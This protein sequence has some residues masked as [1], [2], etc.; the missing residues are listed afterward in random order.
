MKKCVDVIPSFFGVV[1]MIEHKRGLRSSYQNPFSFFVGTLSREGFV[2]QIKNFFFFGK[3]PVPLSWE[4][5][6]LCFFSNGEKTT[7]FL[8]IIFPQR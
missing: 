3:P 2:F 8:G 7:P 5:G 4:R 6:R 1:R